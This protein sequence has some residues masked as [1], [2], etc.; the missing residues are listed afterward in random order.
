MRLAGPMPTA[1]YKQNRSGLQAKLQQASSFVLPTC[2]H[3]AK[4]WQTV[5]IILF[6]HITAANWK[7]Q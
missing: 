1:V 7:R 5:M 2:I 4:K 6:L 3:T